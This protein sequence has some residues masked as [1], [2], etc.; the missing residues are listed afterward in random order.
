[1]RS[2]HQNLSSAQYYDD[3]TF[4]PHLQKKKSQIC[5]FVFKLKIQCLS[6][7]ITLNSHGPGF[8]KIEA[9]TLAGDPAGTVSSF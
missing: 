4:S 1:M 6:S 2:N 5:I 9:Q 3:V 7:T 8:E